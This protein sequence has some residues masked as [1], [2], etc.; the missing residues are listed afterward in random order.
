MFIY[1]SE[2][3]AHFVMEMRRLFLCGKRGGNMEGGQRYRFI[4]TKEGRMK[5]D[6][7]KKMRLQL[8]T[9]KPAKAEDCALL[10]RSEE[11]RVGKECRL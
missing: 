2:N 10:L 6:K 3:D 5:R 9:L 1:E 7:F 8:E 4:K 11:R